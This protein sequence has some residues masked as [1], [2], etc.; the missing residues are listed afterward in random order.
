V[1]GRFCSLWCNGGKRVER[2]SVGETAGS[3]VREASRL[4]G[5]L[6]AL[7]PGTGEVEVARLNGLGTGR[8]E[9]GCVDPVGRVDREAFR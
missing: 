8:E 9:F 7:F 4:A 5:R 3:G 1:D 2:S 6:T